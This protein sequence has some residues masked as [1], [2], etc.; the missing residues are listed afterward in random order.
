MVKWLGRLGYGAKKSPEGLNPGFDIRRL[1]NSLCQHSSKWVSGSNQGRIRQRKERDELRL[2]YA[3]PTIHGSLT[4]MLPRLL[5][6]RISFFF[7]Q[8]RIAKENTGHFGICY[9][10]SYR[11]NLPVT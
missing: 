8:N 3:A 9:S 5:G 2:S 7:Y 4:S 6:I 11:R 1:Q 10:G